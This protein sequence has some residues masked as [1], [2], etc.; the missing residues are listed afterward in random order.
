METAGSEYTRPDPK[1]SFQP[2]KPAS[3]HPQPSSSMLCKDNARSETILSFLVLTSFLSFLLSSLSHLKLEN[4]ILSKERPSICLS[5]L[6][7]EITH[8]KI[9]YFL[10]KQN[11]TNSK[12]PKKSKAFKLLIKQ[13]PQ[14]L[15]NL[16]LYFSHTTV[17]RKKFIQLPYAEN[18][19]F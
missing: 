16:Y 12:P 7:F 18:I 5:F 15:K 2:L 17:N 11:I 8:E 6:Y 14:F 19:H 4:T 3:S 13:F 1:Q 10:T 9:V